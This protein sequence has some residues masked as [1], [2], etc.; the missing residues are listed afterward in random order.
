MVRELMINKQIKLVDENGQMSLEVINSD[1][2]KQLISFNIDN[3]MREQML[4]W[5]NYF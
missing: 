2:G 5:L 1:T 4:E 3:D